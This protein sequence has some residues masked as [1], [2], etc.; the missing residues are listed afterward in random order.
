MGKIGKE[1]ETIE[2]GK[3]KGAKNNGNN[4]GRG[5]RNRTGKFRNKGV[6]RGR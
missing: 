3:E 2:R 6:D 1:L 5:G 4:K